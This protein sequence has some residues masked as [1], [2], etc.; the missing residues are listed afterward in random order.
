MWN[1]FDSDIVVVA[2]VFRYMKEN[3]KRYGFIEDNM[4]KW[5]YLPFGPGNGHL[6]NSTSFM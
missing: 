3:R 2:I 5:I 6:N 4:N 1:Y